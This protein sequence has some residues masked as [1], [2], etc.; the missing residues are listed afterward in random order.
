MGVQF[1]PR[2][3]AYLSYRPCG[4][5][6]S[7]VAARL[8][9]ALG[10]VH[11]RTDEFRM[12]LRKQGKSFSIAP[13]L[14]A[15]AR[16]KALGEGKSVVADFDAVLPQRQKECRVIARKYGMPCYFVRIETPEDVIIRRARKHRYTSRDF[17][18]NADE[19]LRVYY[20]RRKLHEKQLQTKADF[21]I[22]NAHPLAPQI[23]AMVKKMKGGL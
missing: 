12:A 16:D 11:I 4:I 2:A 23:R 19:L 8:A 18:R 10:A 7:Y 17:F 22:H 9:R 14:A 13:R 6:K 5:R 3:Y 1:P 15:H 20:I 21:V